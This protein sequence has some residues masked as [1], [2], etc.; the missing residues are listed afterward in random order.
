MNVITL[1]TLLSYFFF[2]FYLDL[3]HLFL[4]SIFFLSLGIWD[5]EF[6]NPQCGDQPQ[7]WPV[8]PPGYVFFFF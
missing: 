3:A 6:M 4:S 5:P 7:L 8:L 1:L 2:C